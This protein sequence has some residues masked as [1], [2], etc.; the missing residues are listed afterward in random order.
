M[1]DLPEWLRPIARRSEGK[2]Y[3]IM[4]NL[5]AKLRRCPALFGT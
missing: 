2:S 4:H 5:A 3:G 1:A